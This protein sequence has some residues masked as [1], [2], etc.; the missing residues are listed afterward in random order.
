MQAYPLDFDR[1]LIYYIQCAQL[2]AHR[3]ALGFVHAH[4][5]KNQ[6]NQSFQHEGRGL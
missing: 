3:T 6:A 5:G 1:Q 2:K 4:S